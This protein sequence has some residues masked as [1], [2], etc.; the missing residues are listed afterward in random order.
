MRWEIVESDIY[1]LCV[2]Q[3]GGAKYVDR[4]LYAILDAIAKNPNGFPSTGIKDIRLA[5][6]DIVFGSEVIPALNVRFRIVGIHTVEL[7]HLEICPPEDMFDDDE[8]F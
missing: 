4:A 2:A 1:S 8:D 7:L 3:N 6:T 5:K